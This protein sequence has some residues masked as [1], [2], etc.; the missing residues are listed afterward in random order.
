M[1]EAFG[2]GLLA[3]SSLLLAGLMVFWV[4]FPRRV[5]GALAGFGAGA[6]LAAISFDLL[7]ET[8]GLDAW[9]LGLWMMVG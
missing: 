4:A 8:E 3:Q 7:A 2:L 1:F 5:V 9:Q 6:M